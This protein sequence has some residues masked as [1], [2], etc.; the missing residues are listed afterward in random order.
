ME[1]Y[2]M[3]RG[4]MDGTDAGVIVSEGAPIT[5]PPGIRRLEVD[6][7][8]R[9]RTRAGA[10]AQECVAFAAYREIGDGI[11]LL[12]PEDPM[13]EQVL[14]PGD[15]ESISRASE[16]T[17]RWYEAMSALLITLNIIVNVP[18]VFLLL[19]LLIR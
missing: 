9:R 14:V 8:A 7:P 10:S 13:A 19:S 5:L 17:A 6:L 15:P 11:E 12:K 2:L 16:R 3:V 4:T 18:I 1:P